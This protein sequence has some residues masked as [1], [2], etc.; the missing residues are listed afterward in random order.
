VANT[1][2]VDPITKKII[3]M[4]KNFGLDVNSMSDA[5]FERIKK[6]Y[7]SKPAVNLDE[8]LEASE[9]F[10]EEFSEDIV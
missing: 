6:L 4:L 3:R 1:K 8:D 7:Q 10:S 2:K 9:K 5:E